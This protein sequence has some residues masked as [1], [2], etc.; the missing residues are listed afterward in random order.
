MLRSMS[1]IR[2]LI[3]ATFL[4]ALFT[5]N[6]SALRFTD[7]AYLSPKGVVGKPYTHTFE[8]AKGGGSPPY[9]FKIAPNGKLPPGLT[10]S[11]EDG[12]IA[13]TPL[14]PGTWSVW[15]HGSDS[16]L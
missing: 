13:G 15:L 10:L 8:L 7:A 2:T 1:N 16:G 4:P 14:A 11:Q 5:L 3:L 12:K 6:A 9:H